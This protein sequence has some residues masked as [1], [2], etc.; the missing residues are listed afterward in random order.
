M[1]QDHKLK[2]VINVAWAYHPYRIQFGMGKV[3][4]ILHAYWVHISVN[5]KISPSNLKRYA[6]GL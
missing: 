5:A 3:S 4:W 2:G 6:P 1:L